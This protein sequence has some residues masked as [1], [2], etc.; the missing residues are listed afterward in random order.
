MDQIVVLWWFR[1]TVEFR[2]NFSKICK[3]I[4]KIWQKENLNHR[5]CKEKTETKKLQRENQNQKSCKEKTEE[6]N[7]QR[8]NQNRKFAKRKPKPK[9]SQRECSLN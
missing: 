6:K 4:T 2:R 3:G 7:L 9:I 5:F 8:E 1:K